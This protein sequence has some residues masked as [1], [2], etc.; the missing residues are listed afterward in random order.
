MTGKA[1]QTN[2]VDRVTSKCP[3]YLVSIVRQFFE[4]VYT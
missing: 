1:L 3:I 2:K 4:E